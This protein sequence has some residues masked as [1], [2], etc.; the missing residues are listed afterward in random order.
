RAVL[1]FS[2]SRRELTD[3]DALTSLTAL[4]ETYRTL[5]S[6]IYYAHPPAALIAKAL[7]SALEDFL[8]GYKQ[9]ESRQALGTTGLKDGEIFQLLVFMARVAR[10]HTNGRPRSRMFLNWLTAQFP[11]LQAATAAEAPRIIIP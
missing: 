11:E 1:N 3:Q 7:Y 4:A 8:K 9:E 2:S 10:T 6:G 5:T